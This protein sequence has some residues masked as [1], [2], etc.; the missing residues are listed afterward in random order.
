MNCQS[1][2]RS[3]CLLSLVNKH[4]TLL[5]WHSVH[6]LQGNIAADL[7][8]SGCICKL[9]AVLKEQHRPEKSS[10]IGNKSIKAILPPS[11]AV[12][13]Y[14]KICQIKARPY[15]HFLYIRHG[16]MMLSTTLL[17]LVTKHLH[18]FVCWENELLPLHI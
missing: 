9:V 7:H 1:H 17:K 4:L 16:V 6:N 10:S 18:L 3:N 15:S 12:T 13:K 14:T 2:N 5:Q 11:L 8:Q